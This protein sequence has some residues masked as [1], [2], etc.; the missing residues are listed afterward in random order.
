[1]INLALAVQHNFGHKILDHKILHTS[2]AAFKTKGAE[3]SLTS[4]M[5]GMASMYFP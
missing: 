4:Y 2:P 3:A 1:M 5:P